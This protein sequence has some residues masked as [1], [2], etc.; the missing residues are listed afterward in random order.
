[1][2]KKYKRHL[3]ISL[4]I[5]VGLVLSAGFILML[6]ILELTNNLVHFKDYEVETVEISSKDELLNLSQSYANDNY[7]LKEDLHLKGE[8]YESLNN[9]VLLGK[10]DGQG[11]TIYIEDYSKSLFY[12]VRAS[13]TII[14]LN[15]VLQG[16]YYENDIFGGIASYNFGTIENVTVTFDCQESSSNYVNL[17]QTK[18]FGGIT[19]I[20]KGKINS[21]ICNNLN[22]KEDEKYLSLYKIGGIAGINNQGTISNVLSIMDSYYYKNTSRED[23]LNNPKLKEG[24]IYGEDYS[25]EYDNIY[26]FSPDYS[27]TDE[28][29]VNLLKTLDEDSF[30][31]E[32]Q[33]SNDFSFEYDENN[34][35]YDIHIKEDNDENN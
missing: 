23:I 19:A 28:D 33:F 32:L 12:E 2:N 7:L 11:K 34:N 20:N 14:N 3:L 22:F 1:M 27:L 4:S 10:F 26:S 18:Y 24:Y 6:L 9:I 21:S 5:I 13:A 17:Y 16:Q 35:L 15:I 29:K 30:Y 31:N 25:G 8:D